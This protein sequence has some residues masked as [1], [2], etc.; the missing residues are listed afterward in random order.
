MLASHGRLGDMEL[1]TIVV[2]KQLDVGDLP[3]RQVSAG[4]AHSVALMHPSRGILS[5][6]LAPLASAVDVPH[7]TL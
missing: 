5:P 7:H 6:L 4:G 1:K 3:V 2:P